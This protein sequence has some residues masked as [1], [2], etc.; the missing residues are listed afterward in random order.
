MS[1]YMKHLYLQHNYMSMKM[2]Y[3]SVEYPLLGGR[4]QANDGFGNIVEPEKH[5]ESQEP[6]EMMDSSKDEK[7][8]ELEAQLQE[9]KSKLER[10][11]RPR[12]I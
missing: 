6:S 12:L 11:S 1:D 4:G 7:I 3:N 10:T 2:K 9:T 5:E 8:A